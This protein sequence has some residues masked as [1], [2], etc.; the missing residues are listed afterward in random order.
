MVME[1]MFTVSRVL[2]EA[3]AVRRATAMFRR[4]HGPG[5]Y[6][7]SD[8]GAP[9]H[10]TKHRTTEHSLIQ[11]SGSDVTCILFQYSLMSVNLPFSFCDS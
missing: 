1:V 3:A 10:M 6:R 5:R 9:S 7:A 8:P 11:A 2:L 4:H